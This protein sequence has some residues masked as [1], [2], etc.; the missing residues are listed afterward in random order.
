[1]SV[2]YDLRRFFLIPGAWKLLAAMLVYGCGT[3]ILVPMNAIYL[4]NGVHLSKLEISLVVSTAIIVNLSITLAS[5]LLSDRLRRRKPFPVVASALCVI[6]LFGYDHASTFATALVFYILATTPSGAIVGQLYAM[7]RSHF[8]EEAPDIVDMALVWLRTL[9]SF[10]FFVGLLL[11][12]ALYTAISFH[13]V[14]LGNLFSYAVLFLLFLSYRERQGTPPTKR[15]AGTSVNWFV[16]MAVLI[17][18]CSDNIRS[19][20]FPLMVDNLYKNPVLVSH[21][22]TVQVVFEF[23]WM[24]LGGIAAQRFGDTRVVIVA[25]VCSICVYLTYALHPILPLLFGAQPI[26]SFFVSVEN[27]VAMGMIQRMFLHRSGF[28]SSL[29]FVLSQAASFI[30]YMIPN[31]IPGLSPHIFF[32]PSV[33]S[34][35]ALLLLAFQAHRV[36]QQLERA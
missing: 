29:Y 26:Y 1:M 3:G 28:G 11:G 6:G 22:W 34:C 4:K 24:T 12:S 13:G 35:G 2:L 16:L 10:G 32:I 33:L 19:L 5:G 27:T 14:I 25:I 31:V 20:Y 23:V 9:M 21:L 17:I 15:Q 18:L 30:G 7:A 8:V 36:R